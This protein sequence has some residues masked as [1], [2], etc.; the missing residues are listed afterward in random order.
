MQTSSIKGKSISLTQAIKEVALDSKTYG[1]RGMFRG[2]GI[3][4]PK[5]CL[6]TMF[7][8][9]AFTSPTPSGTTT[10]KNSRDDIILY[11]IFIIQHIT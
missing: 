6:L 1:L 3:G 5:Q 9:V 8:R 4:M 2:Q 10:T 7:H 11:L